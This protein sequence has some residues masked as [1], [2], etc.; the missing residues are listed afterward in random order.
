MT[1]SAIVRG[2]RSV[3]Q[4]TLRLFSVFTLKSKDM[5]LLHQK[6]I[7][8]MLDVVLLDYSANIPESREAEVLGL[9]S[10]IINQLKEAMVPTIPRIF[11]AIFE[12]TVLMIRENY[13][14]H[15]EIRVQFFQFLHAVNSHCFH[16]RLRTERE[17]ER[18]IALTLFV[19]ALHCFAGAALFLL[20]DKYVGAVID[21]IVWAFKHTRRDISDTGL[22]ILRDL[23]IKI[24]S[25]DAASPFHQTYYTR[26]LDELFYVL[27][28]TFHKSGFKMQATMLMLLFQAVESNQIR[29][30]L[31]DPTTVSFP[32]NKAFVRD[33]VIRLIGGAFQNLSAYV[34]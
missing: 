24:S 25:S 14:D 1:S 13:H 19:C 33:F 7:P 2:W 28:D 18:I 15:P 32:D 10:T 8:P 17:R 3:K 9:L 6:F 23:W 26:L 20:P 16:G 21:S 5:V 34:C 31:F 11:E 27:V 29:V 22:E 4:E 12:C 30:P